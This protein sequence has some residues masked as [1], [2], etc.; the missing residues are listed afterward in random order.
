MQQSKR[1]IL[2]Y[3]ISKKIV[4]LH[5]GY[6]RVESAPGIGNAFHLTLTCG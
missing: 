4:E 2:E 3:H 1:I 6:I 5:N